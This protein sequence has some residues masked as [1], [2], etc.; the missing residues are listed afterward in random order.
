MP[1]PLFFLYIRYFFT[2]FFT[3]FDIALNILNR[4]KPL[5]QILDNSCVGKQSSCVNVTSLII[6]Q[7]V[8]FVHLFKINTHEM[9]VHLVLFFQFK[10]NKSTKFSGLFFGQQVFWL[11]IN[12]KCRNELHYYSGNIKTYLTSKYIK[13]I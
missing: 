9:H 10:F 5:F 13:C 6:I 8:I 3:F 2:Y 1:P 7:H 4:F 11:N 12:E